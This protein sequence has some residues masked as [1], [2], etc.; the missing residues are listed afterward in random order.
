MGTG[1]RMGNRPPTGIL[2]LVFPILSLKF[3]SP[4]HLALPA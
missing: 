1:E 2:P 3:S 4:S